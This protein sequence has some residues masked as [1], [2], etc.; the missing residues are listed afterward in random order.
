MRN[1]FWI[2]KKIQS[3]F[4]KNVDGNVA[5]IFSLCI[6]PLFAF[7]GFAVDY[8]RVMQL[9]TIAQG[10]ADAAALHAST[11]AKSLIVLTDGSTKSVSASFATATTSAESMFA[12]SLMGLQNA[13]ASVTI[14][15]TKVGQVISAD[16]TYQLNVPLFFGAFLNTSQQKAS[17]VA[18]S[19]ASIPL[20]TDLYMALDVS[21][22]MG[23]AATDAEAK[24]MFTLTAKKEKNAGNPSPEGCVFGCHVSSS[25]YL[26]K[27]YHDIAKEA[28][29]NLRIDTL[30]QAVSNVIDG[31]EQNS[32]GTGMYRVGLYTM[33]LASS[34]ATTNGLYEL[35]PISGNFSQLR[36]AA[37]SVDLGPNNSGGTGD[38]FFTEQLNTLRYKIK[39][40]GDGSTQLN[41]KAYLMIVTDG[42]RDVPGACGYGHCTAA[43][44]D[45][46]CTQFKNMGVTVVVIYTTYLPIYV[47]PNAKSKSLAQTYI[48]LVK[49][50]IAQIP[51]NLKACASSSDWYAEASDGPALS[52]AIAQMFANTLAQ[53]RLTK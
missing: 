11:V 37:A 4:R 15:L 33:G 7:M 1:Q 43:F 32:A 12:A 29:I 48:D 6:V 23:L 52:A 25:S 36:N 51:I 45:S 39:S 9:R 44:D 31:A 42:L 26:S 21:Q 46:V 24:Q 27:S 35:S 20:Y 17:G 38:S 10:A 50:F 47:D 40:Y 28:G 49:P 30:K 13:N 14:K 16:A 22:S 2:R 3:D 18:T 53:T 5:L 34:Y 41:A 19:T 8:G